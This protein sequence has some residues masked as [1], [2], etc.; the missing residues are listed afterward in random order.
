MTL[1]DSYP[2]RVQGVT[3]VVLGIIGQTHH[4]RQVAKI[5]A[6]LKILNILLFCS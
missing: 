3:A 2:T 5:V 6:N 1:A 4:K